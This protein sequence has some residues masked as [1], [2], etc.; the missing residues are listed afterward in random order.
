MKY[1][2]PVRSCTIRGQSGASRWELVTRP[3]APA[4]RPYLRDLCGYTETT[5][6]LHRRREF[7]LPQVVVIFEFGPPVRIHDRGSSDSWRFPGG[8]VAGVDDG[9]SLTEHDG[10]QQ[11]LQ[12]N[13]TPLGG[14]VL[15][16]LPM[17][18][19][20]G[21][22]VSLDDALPPAHRG[23]AARLHGQR[24]WDARFD[25]FEQVLGERIAGAPPPSGPVTWAVREIEE[26]GGAVD[27][28][29]LARAM[30][31]SQRHTIALFREHVGVP[32]KRLAR[33]VRF[34]RLIRHLK[35]GG[36][37]TWADLALQFGYYDQSHLVR[38]VREFTGITPTR[39]RVLLLDFTAGEEPAPA[40]APIA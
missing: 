38:D 3:P 6:G 14:R 32:P 21:R 4:L 11:G 9:V 16:G 30:G 34:D 36:E 28:R 40:R 19:L 27:V 33:L 26:R 24:D 8:F 35:Q 17:S 5:P 15:F 29:A 2:A 18:E 37:G 12:A 20:T 10:F 13:L 22:V 1:A 23:L 31:Y 7:P 39:A 25:L